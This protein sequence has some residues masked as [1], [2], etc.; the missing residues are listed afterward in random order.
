MKSMKLK[1]TM[2]TACALLLAPAFAEI[3]G[4]NGDG[5][6]YTLDVEM[7]GEGS[8]EACTFNGAPLAGDVIPWTSFKPGRNVLKIQVR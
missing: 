4:Y 7:T 5:V 2:T 3:D 1:M 6:P 8:K